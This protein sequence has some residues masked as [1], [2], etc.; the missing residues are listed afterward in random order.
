MRTLRF[1]LVA[2]ASRPVRSDGCHGLR[3]IPEIQQLKLF[4]SVY[5]MRWP[6]EL[7]SD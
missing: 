7:F 4:M 6:R 3:P 2:R 1:L 5:L